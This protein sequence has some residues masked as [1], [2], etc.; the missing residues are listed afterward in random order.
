MSESVFYLL[1]VGQYPLG[2]DS[3]AFQP[4]SKQAADREGGRGK[5]SAGGKGPTPQQ[6]RSCLAPAE[7]GWPGARA[8]G[9]PMF[10]KSVLGL[11]GGQ[12]CPVRI[13]IPFQVL[14]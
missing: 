3:M 5:A 7:A 9:H 13:W 6:Q 14:G 1:Q 10:P 8:G 11:S 2:P 12:A 4:R